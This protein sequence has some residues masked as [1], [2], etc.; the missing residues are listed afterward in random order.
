MVRVTPFA[1][2][3]QVVEIAKVY[4]S[5]ADHRLDPDHVASLCASFQLLGGE[6]LIQP[7]VVDETLQLI[8][9]AHRLAAAKQLGWRFI[10]AV[11]F[12]HVSKRDR[13]LMLAEANRVRKRLS[14][15]DLEQEW[16]KLY[17]PE[18]EYQ[19]KQ[20]QL[21]G[22]RKRFPHLAQRIHET[23][24]SSAAP[25]IGNSNNRGRAYW[26]GPRARAE[27]LA[28]AAKRITGYSIDTLNKVASIRGI[29]GSAT[30]P[31]ELRA[32]AIQGLQDIA[33]SRA[34]VDAVFRQLRS[35]VQTAAQSVTEPTRAATDPGEV[36]LE[37]LLIETSSIAE[38]LGGP[39]SDAL[40]G[41]R[42]TDPVGIQLLEGVRSSLALALA[43]VAAAE[44]LRD[45]Q[46]AVALRRILTEAGKLCSATA[47][48][49]IAAAAPADADHLPKAA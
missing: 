40:N 17:A 28:K 39:S 13:A 27:S 43:H 33:V 20:R 36:F 16:R 2:R 29:A 42:A 6:L 1:R 45:D 14:V 21:A 44:S 41:V 5:E 49:R 7:I 23:S 35:G 4:L 9:G 31:A 26:E 11:V 46:P 18:L 3:W 19:A 48:E 8:D 32:A 47:H 24:P 37:R 30:A 10:S 25:V 12:A 34:S 38:R 22:L 15:I